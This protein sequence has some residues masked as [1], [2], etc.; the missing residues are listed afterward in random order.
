M[1]IERSVIAERGLAYSI[2]RTR[3][4]LVEMLAKPLQYR[5]HR[6]GPGPIDQ[7]ERIVALIEQLLASHPPRCGY[8]RSL[9]RPG[10]RVDPEKQATGPDSGGTDSD[11]RSSESTPAKITGTGASPGENDAKAR[12]ATGLETANLLPDRPVR[13]WSQAGRGD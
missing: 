2:C 7:L 12:P 6:F 3:P 9:L 5:L 13:R 1:F 4:H 8:K 11:P 10:T